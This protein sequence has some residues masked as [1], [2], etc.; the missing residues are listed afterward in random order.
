MLVPL[1]LATTVPLVTPP[2]T[3]VPVIVVPVSVVI[4]VLPSAANTMLLLPLLAFL[5]FV[6]DKVFISVKSPVMVPP[7]IGTLFDADT[8]P[9]LPDASAVNPVLIPAL[10]DA[11]AVSPILIPTLPE[12][13]AVSPVLIPAL[14]EASAINPVLIP[15]LPEARA[16]P[17][18][19]NAALP[20][21]CA[22]VSVP[23]T[24]SFDSKVRKPRG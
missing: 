5:T 1:V 21:A 23:G 11:S 24:V 10:P 7:E 14:P 2:L 22:V 3:E 8:N 15:A 6:V 19:T 20:E 17:A 18:R 12:A 9:A 4:V 16:L 13:N